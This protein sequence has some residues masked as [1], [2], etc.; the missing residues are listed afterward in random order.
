M[1]NSVLRDRRQT[2]VTAINTFIVVVVGFRLSLSMIEIV[3]VGIVFVGLITVGS[4]AAM[5]C[6]KCWRR[7]N[8]TQ[9]SQRLLELGIASRQ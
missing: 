4:I 2:S 9:H 8:D 5:A 7:R 6:Y 1:V 3:Y